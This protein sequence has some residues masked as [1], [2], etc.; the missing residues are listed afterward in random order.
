MKI[1]NK[2]T[3]TTLETLNVKSNAPRT[4]EMPRRPR[5]F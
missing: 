5:M 3:Q 1:T 4:I 2:F